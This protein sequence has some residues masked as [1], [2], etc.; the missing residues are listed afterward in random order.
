MAALKP[1]EVKKYDAEWNAFVKQ[2]PELG[3]NKN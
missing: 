1:K 2:N 3:L